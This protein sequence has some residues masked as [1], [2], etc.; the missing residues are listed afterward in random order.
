MKTR[1]LF[2]M[3]LVASLTLLVTPGAAAPSPQTPEPPGESEPEYPLSQEFDEQPSKEYLFDLNDAVGQSIASV[4][5]WGERIDVAVTGDDETDPAVALCAY[6]QYLVTYALEG[7]IY[8]QRLTSGGDLLGSPFLISSDSYEDTQPDVACEWASNRFVVVWRHNFGDSGDYDIY[9]RG[10]HGGH[11]TSG[12]QLY[13]SQLTVS[14]DGVDEESPAIACN[15]NEH[16]CLVA[17]DYSGTGSGDIYAQ[18]VSVG[19]SDIGKDGDRFTISTYAAEEHSPDVT[20]GGHDDDYLVVWQYLYNDPADHYKIVTAYVWDTNQAGDQ[21]ETD[22]TLLIGPGPYDHDQTVPAAAYNR[23][24]RQYL[25]TWQ[26]DYYGDG[27]DYDVYALRLTPGGGSVG[28]A[29]TVAGTS[30]D[31]MSPAVAFSGGPEDLP[32]MGADQ[33]LVTYVHAGNTA[34]E[35]RG[36]PIKGTHDTGGYQLE[37]DS[38]QIRTTGSGFNYGIFRPDVTGSVN[39]G[40]YL[41]VWEDMIGGFAGY[42]Y[43]VLGQILSSGASVYLPLILDGYPSVFDFQPNPDGYSFRN[44]GNAS[45]YYQDDLG[46]GDLINMFGAG[47]VCAS[48]ST[49]A[50]CVL[51]S[52]AEAWRQQMLSWMNG[53]HC[54]GMAVTSLR[55]FKGQT[56]YTGDTT[57][58]DFQAGAQ[59]VYDLARSQAIDNYIAYYFALQDVEEVWQPT[60]FIRHNSTPS[61]QL[62]MVRQE[63]QSGNDPFSL[64]VYDPAL[65]VGHAIV[66][67]DVE[68]RGGGI[69]RLYVYDNNDPGDTSLYITFDTNNDTWTYDS[70]FSGNASTKSLSLSRLSLRTGEPFTA[71]FTA[72][73]SAVEFFTTNGGD[74]LIT[75]SRGQR[76]GYDPATGQMVNEIPG[77]H[78]VYL[79]GVSGPKYWIP[80]GEAG[81]TYGV[82]VSGEN[83]SAQVNTDLVMVGP[84]YVVGF[85]D[86]PLRQSQ[87]LR[88]SLSADGRELAFEEGQLEKAPRMFQA[89][90]GLER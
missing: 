20:W 85:E 2:V 59:T 54:E 19:G 86:I 51:T 61:Q 36:R 34:T 44:Y 89:I 3:V 75:N 50:N 73:A 13:G 16:T 77:A 25:V 65:T 88:M 58:G 24:V 46:A 80:L 72:N 83:I 12:S 52:A 42:D 68:D 57:P 41:T 11:Q 30:D 28:S 9:A 26:Y 37:G 4:D 48:G 8:G 49:P 67:Y 55:F 6:D 74:L 1:L 53:G 43:D 78:V 76:I 15:I 14:G 64:N 63:L 35:V 82:T 69:Y 79:R 39:N 22:G 5:P 62:D 7:E 17:F 31:E 66:P 32:G 45:H 47:T 38:I 60:E 90:D 33:F 87:S 71:P 21:I 18:R 23:D 40:H 29:F 81:E 70:T 84:G 56:Y 10:V 27:S